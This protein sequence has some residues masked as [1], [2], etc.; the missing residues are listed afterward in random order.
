MRYRI[1]CRFLFYSYCNHYH[2]IYKVIIL[3]SIIFGMKSILTVCLWL[4]TIFIM[5]C[6]K[7]GIS[8]TTFTLSDFRAQGK[9]YEEGDPDIETHLG[10]TRETA[11]VPLIFKPDGTLYTK[12]DVEEI[13]PCLIWEVECDIENYFYYTDQSTFY[14]VTKFPYATE[15]YVINVWKGATS[16]EPYYIMDP[17]REK[18]MTEEEYLK[19][20]R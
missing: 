17:Y 2:Y 4:F 15:D 3:S 18:Q 8:K 9:V 12:D 7:D 19:Q 1:L 20:W 14:N 11:M 6:Q 13:R 5:G 10:Q 16:S